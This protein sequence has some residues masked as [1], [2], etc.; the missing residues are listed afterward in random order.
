MTAPSPS[1]EPAGHCRFSTP[2]DRSQFVAL[3]RA[4]LTEMRE[5]GSSRL[6][7]EHNLYLSWEYFDAYTTGRLDGVV[8]LWSPEPN[9]PSQGAVLAGAD[10]F[11]GNWHMD[12]GGERWANLWGV[13]VAPEFRGARVGLQMELYG[14]PRLLQQG[15]HQVVTSVM[16]GNPLGRAN[17]DHW[18]GAREVEP[19]ETVIVARLGQRED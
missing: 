2:H 11:E 5:L 13:Y 17:W 12:R 16:A 18:D 15:F 8:V 4:F 6:A 9:G 10:H 3:W 1:P 19:L 7:D 14:E